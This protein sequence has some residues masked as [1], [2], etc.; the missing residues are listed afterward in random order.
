[1]P[2]RSGRNI[3]RRTTSPEVYIVLVLSV[4][5]ARTWEAG[6]NSSDQRRTVNVVVHSCYDGAFDTLQ[7][8]RSL[9]VA[10]MHKVI[11]SIQDKL[12]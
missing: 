4:A 5:L 8:L 2:I 10:T 6:V 12:M 7:D 1:M 3:Q 11:A 9:G